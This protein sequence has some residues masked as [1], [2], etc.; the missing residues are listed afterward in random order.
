MRTA[1][2]LALLSGLAAFV[3]AVACAGSG[4]EESFEPREG[5]VVVPADASS[6]LLFDERGVS[7]RSA[8]AVEWVQEHAVHGKPSAA[9]VDLDGGWACVRYADQLAF[10]MLGAREADWAPSPEPGVY[11]AIAVKGDLAAVTAKNRVHLLEVPTGEV[12]DSFDAGAWIARLDQDDVDYALPISG[13]EVMLM[14]SRR[15]GTFTDGKVVAFLADRS[16]GDWRVK[17]QVE[18]PGLTWVHRCASAGDTVYVSG[19]REETQLQAGNRP[20]ELHQFLVV[21]AVDPNTLLSHELVY[22][23]RNLPP[24]PTI[25][26]DLAVGTEALALLVEPGEIRVYS[27][28]RGALLHERFFPRVDSITWLDT[29][30]L[31]AIVDGQPQLVRY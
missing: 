20:P 31:V 11:R 16:Q 18:F 29:G 14:T 13:T 8:D 21:Q 5:D 10:V 24:P 2:A 3:G 9:G 19:L 23:R 28:D 15:V 22:E 7:K 12:V 1:P 25:V 27:L 6:F 17:Q 4:S 26:R 30:E